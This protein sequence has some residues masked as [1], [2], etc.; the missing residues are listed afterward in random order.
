M[1]AGERYR[2]VRREDNDGRPDLPEYMELV[3]YIKEEDAYNYLWFY[4]NQ[5]KKSNHPASRQDI[6]DHYI[7]EEK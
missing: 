1:R 3:R 2:F 4:D 7:K 6:L 5:W